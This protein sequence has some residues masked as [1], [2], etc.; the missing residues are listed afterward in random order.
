MKPHSATLG[1]RPSYTDL[2]HFAKDETQ[3]IAMPAGSAAG[4]D[5]FL[6]SRRILDLPPGPVTVGAISLEAGSGAV[7]VQPADEII[8]VSKGELTLA[9]QDGTLVLGRGKSVVLQHGASFSWS[10]EGP[11]SVIFMRYQ[12]SKA[13]ERRLVTVSETPSLQPSAPPSAELL[14]TP[15]PACRNHVDHRSA[16]GEFYCGTWD[17]TPYHRR[18][19]SYRH[20]ELIHLLEGSFTLEDDTGRSSTFVPG[21]IVLVARDAQCSWEHRQHV[22]KVYAIYRPA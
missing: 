20:D 12:R 15:T 9:Q 7:Q 17:S 11:V 21:D 22:T 4:E 3:G 1:V 5:L 2:R 13:V 10:A 6:S 16:D 19:M 14:L 8:I 18:A